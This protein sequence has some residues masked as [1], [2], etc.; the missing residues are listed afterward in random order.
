MSRLSRQWPRL[1]RVYVFL[2]NSKRDAWAFAPRKNK[3]RANATQ[4]KVSNSFFPRTLK[5][6]IRK[7]CSCRVTDFDKWTQQSSPAICNARLKRKTIHNLWDQEKHYG[8]NRDNKKN[9]SKSFKKK[10]I[11]IVAKCKKNHKI[12]FKKNFLV[13]SLH[14]HKLNSLSQ[15]QIPE[16]FHLFLCHSV[17]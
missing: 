10:I 15:T 6:Y 3:N 5:I 1:W 2:N 14:Y 13:H 16:I 4:I 9:L 7:Q 17:V 8:Y 12:V 11:F